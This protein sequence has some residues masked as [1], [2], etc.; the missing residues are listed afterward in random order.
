MILPPHYEEVFGE[1]AVYCSPHE[2]KQVINYYSQNADEYFAQV[3]K[4]R[5]V[6]A[7]NFTH[8]AHTR[9]IQ[10][11]LSELGTALSVS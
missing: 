4:S 7:K 5:D 11:L 8:D 6:L 1:A 9:K 3:E 2:V 10:M